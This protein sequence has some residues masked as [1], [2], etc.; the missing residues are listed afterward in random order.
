[1]TPLTTEN[2]PAVAEQAAPGEARRRPLSGTPEWLLRVTIE[3]LL[4]VIS[5][6]AALAVDEFRDGVRNRRLALQSLQIFQREMRQNQA[7]LEDVIPY[8]TGLRDV[9]AGMVA[10][11]AH[12]V[13][14]RSAVEG[15]EP[16]VLL[17]TAWQT[18]LATGALNYIDVETV[19]ALSL[20]YSM[21]QEFY[22]GTRAGP[23]RFAVATA[24]TSAEKLAEIQQILAHLGEVV[25][26]EQEL[27]AVYTNALQ[28]IQ[29]AIDGLGGAPL[30]SADSTS[31]VSQRSGY[32]GAP[33]SRPLSLTTLRPGTTAFSG[34]NVMAPGIAMTSSRAISEL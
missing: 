20:T 18:A 29:A 28:I 32:P 23:P 8:H 4:I 16:V 7:R 26:N 13:E 17:N 30:E 9:V 24:S 10:D 34:R 31:T 3:S 5:I 1:M 15:L 2:E 19:S 11:P 21:Q 12:I 22:D 27:Q 14:V 25:R 6:L 33:G